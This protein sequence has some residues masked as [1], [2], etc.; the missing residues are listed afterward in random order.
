MRSAIAFV[1][2]AGLMSGCG[3]KPAKAIVTSRDVM[4]V[5]PADFQ[6]ADKTYYTPSPHEA[7]SL[8]SLWGGCGVRNV[9]GDCDDWA[10][11]CKSFM[12]REFQRTYKGA[13]SIAVFEWHYNYIGKSGGHA[14]N[15][16]MTTR[17]LRFY[18]PQ[19]GKGI[20]ET[21]DMSNNARAF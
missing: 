19:T 4:Q 8:F 1:I 20:S 7:D 2:M 10:R 15:A 21:K 17:G 13:E 6:P 12:I 11:E 18:E 16:V 3:R 5:M 14:V 9:Y